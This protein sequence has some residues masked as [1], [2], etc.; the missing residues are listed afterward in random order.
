MSE[1][2][3]GRNHEGSPRKG[4]VMAQSFLKAGGGRKGFCS[5]LSSGER[6]PLEFCPLSRTQAVGVGGWLL[7]RGSEERSQKVMVTGSPKSEFLDHSRPTLPESAWLVLASQGKAL[8]L[9]TSLA[10]L[11]QRETRPTGL[12]GKLQAGLVLELGKRRQSPGGISQRCAAPGLWGEGAKGQH[13]SQP[14]VTF[15]GTGPASPSP[16][17]GAA[18]GVSHAG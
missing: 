16:A 2:I 18:R 6:C 3:V 15:P 5:H 4:R 14:R 13:L 1:E 8:G 11:R 10:S 12:D 9:G 7:Q 17:S